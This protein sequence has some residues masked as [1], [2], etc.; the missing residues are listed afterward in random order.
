MQ[1]DGKLL[2]TGTASV[3]C[4]WNLRKAASG[5]THTVKV[6][7]LDTAGNSTSASVSIIKQ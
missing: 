6:T 1:G 4:S 3:S 5:S 7:A 2:C